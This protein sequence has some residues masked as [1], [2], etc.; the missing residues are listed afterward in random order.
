MQ[1]FIADK[2]HSDYLLKE[3]NKDDFDN[4]KNY[5][6]DF[7]KF[8]NIYGCYKNFKVSEQKLKDFLGNQKFEN[9]LDNLFYE[10]RYLF[11]ANILF[12][13]IFVDNVKSFVEQLKLN[14]L[15]KEIKIY[16]KRDELRMM[17]LLRDYSQHFSSPFDDLKQVVSFTENT[18]RLEI[19][20]SKKELSRNKYNNHRN[21][22]YLDSLKD[23]IIPL[24]GYFHRWCR[25]LDEIIEKCKHYFLN[26]TTLQMKFIISQN[27]STI[28]YTINGK[29]KC[30]Y[31]SYVKKVKNGSVR[32]PSGHI[33][34][35][36]ANENYRF[37][38]D[39]LE[40]LFENLS[41]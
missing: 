20:T 17:K 15:K 9:S 3:L 27:F 11:S 37:D 7:L 40:Y 28:N 23:S 2:S 13:R 33:L 25:V 22:V 38:R 12:G 24:T 4:L 1:Y 18:C 31:P 6:S 19:Y 26:F 36:N 14:D 8:S 34:H 16:E 41:E 30:F 39:T 35:D 10:M 21:D 29:T 32:T 5:H